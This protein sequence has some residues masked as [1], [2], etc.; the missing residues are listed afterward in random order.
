MS[1]S[2]EVL[3]ATMTGNAQD[4]AEALVSRLTKEGHTATMHDVADYDVASLTQTKFVFVCISTWGDG[5]PPSDGEDFYDAVQDLEPGSLSH[6]HFSVLSLGDT[7]YE[8]FCQCGKDIDQA[9]ERLGGTRVAPR[10]DCDIDFEDNLT[11]WIDS[12]ASAL[13]DMSKV[14]A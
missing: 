5:E 6:I 1:D 4:C 11:S 8:L 9:F 2:I 7:S 13:A 3:Y 10:M 12:V 14:P